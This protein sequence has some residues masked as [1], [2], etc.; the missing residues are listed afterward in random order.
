MRCNLFFFGHIISFGWCALVKCVI[1]EKVHGKR[2]RG[3]HQIATSRNGLAEV[4][5]KSSATRMI[6]L[7]G[8]NW[9]KVLRGRLIVIPDGI[10]KDEE[11]TS[12]IYHRDPQSD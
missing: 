9:C 7:D 11:G 6:A 5:K 3:I 1:L 2:R 4:W 10:A 12:R 8:E